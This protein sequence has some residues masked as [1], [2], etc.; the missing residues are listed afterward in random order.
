ML[1]SRSLARKLRQYSREVHLCF[2]LGADLES[3]LALT[4]ATLQFHLRN[5]LGITKHGA[6]ASPR[7][8]RIR[9]G[10]RSVDLYLR[11][12]SGD[13]FIFHEVFLGRR[14]WIPEAWRRHV[15][16]IVDLGAHIGLVTLFFTQIFPA[17]RYVCVEPNSANAE[18]LRRN[19][20][21]LGDRAHIIE[22]AIS[23]TSNE[24]YFD[25]S[26]WSWGG[27]LSPDRRSGRLVRCY[28]MEEIMS[29]CGL[30]TIDILKV[31]IEGAEKQLFG[32][33][34][35][36]LGRTKIVVVSELHGTYSMQNFED[37]IAAVGLRVLPPTSEFGNGIIFALSP[38]T[39]EIPH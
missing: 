8:Y 9:L 13:L 22:G 7:R 16:N 1:R 11:S 12:S 34:S 38:D 28:T 25:D 31:H 20:S 33:R 15:T 37:D 18:I 10:H 23:D 2:K 36:W 17:A 14:Y 3:R 21:W 4:A 39:L 32:A 29:M 6:G 35:E 24:A 27:H 26:S 5:G 19:L 30:S